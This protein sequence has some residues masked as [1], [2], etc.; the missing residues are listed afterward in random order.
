VKEMI[1]LHNMS[2]FDMTEDQR[3]LLILDGLIYC[4][5]DSTPFIYTTTP[6]LDEA[7]ENNGVD[8][9]D[10]LDTFLEMTRED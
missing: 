9:L 8:P 10:F 2:Q 1:V 5:D 4:P 6:V 3:I 7:C